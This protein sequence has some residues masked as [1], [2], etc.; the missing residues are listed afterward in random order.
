MEASDLVRPA[1]PARRGDPRRGPHAHPGRG[2]PHP[3]AHGD[4]GHRRR[5]RRH[6]R[7]ARRRST[8]T[9]SV[10]D[11]RA[12][13][14]RAAVVGGIFAP[15]AG[16][17]TRMAE[18]DDARAVHRPRDAE[19]ERPDD[20]RHRRCSAPASAS[21]FC[22]SPARC[23]PA[24]EPLA[25]VLASST[26][27]GR[28]VD[29]RTPA[30]DRPLRS[31]G[32]MAR[33]VLEACGVRLARR[34]AELRARRPHAGA[35]RPRQAR[36]RRRRRSSAPTW[37][38]SALASPVS[39]RP[40]RSPSSRSLAA[41]AA[42]LR[43]ARPCARGT[44]HAQAPAGVP[45]RPLGLPR[46]RQRDPRRRRRHRDRAARRRRRRR[47]LG[48]TPPSARALDRAR[49]TGRSPWDTFAEL[50]RRARGRRA[51]RAGRQR[52]PRRLPRRPHPAVARRQGRHA[53]AATRSPRPK[54][55]PRPPPSA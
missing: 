13:P 55:P 15:A 17:S 19:T 5:R 47:R 48:A 1:V 28:T 21:A 25:A 32:R 24:P 23:C 43:A 50:G 51:G 12:G 7:A 46:P 14:D 6:G 30:V 8:A 20:P 16:S 11:S 3:G 4:Q 42:G 38:A 53:C 49:L 41:A 54:P 9:T 26:D 18:I 34:D 27:R 22:S 29:R 52:V 39:P 37:S 2:R 40:D 31:R 45:P 33:R 35:P 36:R 44:R 10:Y